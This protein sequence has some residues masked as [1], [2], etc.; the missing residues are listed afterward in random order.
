MSLSYNANESPGK[1]RTNPPPP[2]SLSSLPDEMVLRCLALVPRIYHLSL[3]WVSKDLR[4]LVRSP[5]LTKLRPKKSSL[6]VCF[7]EYYNDPNFHWFTLRP[8]EE[9]ETTT[10]YGLVPNPTP[11]S[12]HNYGSSTVVVGSNIYFIGGCRE[13]STDLWILDTQSGSITQGPSMTVRRVKGETAVGVVDG[14]IYVIGGGVSDYGMEVE[15]Y[16][17]K[18]ETWE[19]AGMEK[20]RKIS[21]CCASVERKIF[22][23][24][25]EEINVYNP[26]ECGRERLALMVSQRLERGRKDKLSEIE[27]CVCVV[28]DVLYACFGWS[29]IMWFNTKLNVWRSL[30]GR[31]GKQLFYLYADSMAEYE[32]RLVVFY[33][34]GI[35]NGNDVAVARNVLC[36]FV[37]LHRA[38][39][40]ICGTIDWSGIVA[41][42]PYSFR[43]LHCL[44]VSE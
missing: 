1:Y 24:E 18:S 20:V 44:S 33:S 35:P 16:D 25:F 5:E 11:F 37:S 23:V 12:P 28:E 22:M 15:V 2:P 3:S 29:G 10:E 41:T 36:E 6:Y 42:V 9:T 21:R 38:G 34:N 27:R 31:D 17:L 39:E 13:A 8:I 32:G 7:R 19:S 40:T 4:A 26:R 43:F 30:V 14:K